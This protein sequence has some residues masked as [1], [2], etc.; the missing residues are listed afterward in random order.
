MLL[1]SLFCN[2]AS[3]LVKSTGVLLLS[4]FLEA[5][6][7]LKMVKRWLKLIPGFVS[8]VFFLPFQFF[9]FLSVSSHP[10]L[11]L[12][13]FPWFCFSPGSVIF[14]VSF[15]P[16]LFVSSVF[17][18][19][20]PPLSSRFFLVLSSLRMPCCPMLSVFNAGVKAAVFFFF[21]WRRW[22]VLRLFCVLVLDVLK[23]L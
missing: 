2:S 19:F 3:S 1:R 18:F 8:S 13:F 21:G 15:P 5:E 17:F 20:F 12:P 9:F 10:C 23:V 4:G 16:C 7:L 14:F 22:T 11:S 6:E